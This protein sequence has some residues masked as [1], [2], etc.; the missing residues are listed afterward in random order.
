MASLNIHVVPLVV[1]LE[2][3]LYRE[4]VDVQPGEFYRLLA[5]TEN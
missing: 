4:G 1:T 2:G 5:A 3:T